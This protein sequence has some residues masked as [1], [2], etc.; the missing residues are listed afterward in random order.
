M[1]GDKL[2]RGP[3]LDW[4]ILAGNSEIDRPTLGLLELRTPSLHSALRAS[5][6]PSHRAGGTFEAAT[7]DTA[8]LKAIRPSP[9]REVGS[10]LLH[11]S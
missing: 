6:Y 7:Q 5:T 2:R 10:A 4:P 9:P 8:W 1:L 3:C 11:P